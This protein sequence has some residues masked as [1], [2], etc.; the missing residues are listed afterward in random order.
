VS[1]HNNAK[2]LLIFQ[3]LLIIQKIQIWAFQFIKIFT[4]T[5]IIN[6]K[7]QNRHKGNAGL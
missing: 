4:Q 2:P 1:I 6:T 7:L 3:Q 5:K